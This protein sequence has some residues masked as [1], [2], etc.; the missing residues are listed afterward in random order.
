MRNEF[1]PVAVAL[2]LVTA[3]NLPAQAQ[4]KKIPATVAGG[5]TFQSYCAVCHGADAK[6]ESRLTDKLRVRPP[7]LTLL[8]E[9]NGG[10]Y[11]DDKVFMII[12]G[13]KPVKGH[14]RADMP[15][16]GDAFDNSSYDG[17][18]EERTKEK[19]AAVVEYLK[20]IQ[21]LTR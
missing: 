11:P 10:S 14:G 2:A 3:Q 20:A 7:D 21:A 12:D 15:I 5:A 8:A 16:W 4:E 1:L 6:G 18:S 13:R 19:I 9:R 17:D